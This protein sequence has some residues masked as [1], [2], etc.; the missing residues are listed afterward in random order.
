L[1]LRPENFVKAYKGKIDKQGRMP[2]LGVEYS[3]Y[4]VL[5]FIKKKDKS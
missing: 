2:A 3:D 5:V 1:I 4:D